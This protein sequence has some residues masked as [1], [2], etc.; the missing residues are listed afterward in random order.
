MPSFGYLAQ[1]GIFTC[2]YHGNHSLESS[3]FFRTFLIIFLKKNFPQFITM[4]LAKTV[5][6][7]WRIVFSIY[8]QKFSK[9]RQFSHEK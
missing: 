2:S 5:L 7:S 3:A 6:I 8:V 1:N 9:I 4:V